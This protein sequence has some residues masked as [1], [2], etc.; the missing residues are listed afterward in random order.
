MNTFLSYSSK[1]KKERKIEKLAISFLNCL[2]QLRTHWPISLLGSV[3]KLLAKA[4]AERLKKVLPKIIGESQGAFVKDR[5]IL[6][7]VLIANELVHMRRKEMKLGLLFKIDIEKVYDFVDWSFVG[8]LFSKMGFGRLWCKWMKACTEDT[9][10]SILVNGSSTQPIHANMGLRQG[11]PLSP[12]IFTLVGGSLNKLVEKA[13]EMGVVK[14]FKTACDAP[15][16]SLT[17]CR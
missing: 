6:D 15:S 7:G 13:R 9:S 11:D 10:F 3:Y 8:Y 14:G 16:H 17:V 2:L 4:L 12:F 1:G 5:Q